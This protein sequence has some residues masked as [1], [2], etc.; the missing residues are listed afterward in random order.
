MQRAAPPHRHPP[1]SHLPWPEHSRPASSTGHLHLSPEPPPPSSSAVSQFVPNQSFLGVV[2]S[3]QHFQRVLMQSCARHRHVVS[4][5]QKRACLQKQTVLPGTGT[6][7]VGVCEPGVPPEPP[8]VVVSLVGS[9]QGQSRSYM[10]CPCAVV[11][12][13]RSCEQLKDRHRL[14]PSL[15]GVARATPQCVHS[16][17]ASNDVGLMREIEN[18]STH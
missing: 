1:L 17:L 12:W 7:G 9:K 18:S 3:L 11:T 8:S 2:P 15:Y 6:D 10:R 4:A 13:C 14:Y 5:C 16:I